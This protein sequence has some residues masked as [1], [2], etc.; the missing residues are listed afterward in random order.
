MNQVNQSTIRYH[1]NLMVWKV[2]S[3]CKNFVIAIVKNLEKLHKPAIMI[4]IDTRLSGSQCVRSS[5]KFPFNSHLL[6]EARG[7]SREILL[8]TNNFTVHVTFITSTEQ[9]TDVNVQVSP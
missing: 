2:H 9:K 1:L 4:V 5:N 7:L 6:V 8:L 3:Y